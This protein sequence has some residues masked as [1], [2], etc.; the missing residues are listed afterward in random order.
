MQT[1]AEQWKDLYLDQRVH[2]EAEI[3]RRFQLVQ[4]R[5]A[6]DSTK[7]SVDPSTAPHDYHQTTSIAARTV[8]FDTDSSAISSFGPLRA[9]QRKK[10]DS[11]PYPSPSS[12]RVPKPCNTLRKHHTGSSASIR[13]AQSS[14][15][16]SRSRVSTRSGQP[17]LTRLRTSNKTDD[18]SDDD[19][20]SDGGSDSEYET[21]TNLD[22]TDEEGVEFGE[23]NSK[24]TL[25]EKRIVAKYRAQFSEKQWAKMNGRRMW[26]PVSQKVNIE[27]WL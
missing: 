1:V 24:W 4:D 21:V 17:G 20:L 6:E 15:L 22:S 23:P 8:S 2:I 3:A 7:S 14:A 18:E 11:R 16:G 9:T 25:P 27:G 10:I 19:G 5:G 13:S 12:D 26:E